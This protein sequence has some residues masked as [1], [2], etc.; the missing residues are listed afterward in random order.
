LRRSINTKLKIFWS[1]EEKEYVAI[2]GIL[3]NV[4]AAGKTMEK[5]LL[6]LS[7]DMQVYLQGV[8]EEGNNI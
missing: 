3:P 2:V 7:L 6:R 8:I 1:N 4:R 5:A